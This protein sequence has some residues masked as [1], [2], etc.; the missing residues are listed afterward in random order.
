[1]SPED[2]AEVEGDLSP[3]L[4]E[5]LVFREWKRRQISPKNEN[6][7]NGPATLVPALP[8]VW[9]RF[10]VSRPQK[11]IAKF[12]QFRAQTVAPWKLA[13]SPNSKYF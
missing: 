2:R 3:L 6:E 13:L 5:I 12:L 1:M 10:F 4:Y 11:K 7:E 8:P 9:K